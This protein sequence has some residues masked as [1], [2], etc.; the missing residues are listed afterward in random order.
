MKRLITDRHTGRAS[1]R[2]GI[3]GTV[4]D[5]DVIASARHRAG[6][7]ALHGEVAEGGV[8]GAG[9]GPLHGVHADGRVRSGGTDR[10]VGQRVIADGDIAGG[11]ARD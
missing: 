11:S 6:G 1:T 7:R 9:R 8:V 10:R 4:T 3:Q 2:D 5:R